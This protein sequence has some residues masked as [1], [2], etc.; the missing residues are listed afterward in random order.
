M[1]IIKKK[2]TKDKLYN[3]EKISKDVCFFDIETT[4][5][6][7]TKDIIYLVGVL[8][9]DE[10]EDSWVL[11]QYFANELKDEPKILIES[12]KLLMSFKTIINY[13]GNTFDIPFVNHKLKHFKLPFYIDKEKS[14]DI[15]SVIRKNKDLLDIEN[16]KLKTVERYLNIY[17]EDIYSGKDCI[18]FYKDYILNGDLELK[19]RLL[20]HNYDDLYFLID[21]IDILD[22]IREKK[23]FTI[24]KDNRIIE[25]LISDTSESK[26]SLIFE[27]NV[28]GLRQKLIYYDTSFNL[29]IEDTNKFKIII[30]TNKGL[31]TTDETCT[32]IDKTDFNISKDIKSRHGY[33]LPKDIF[34]LKVGSKYLLE[35]ILELLKNI[36]EDII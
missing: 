35:D 36:I 34:L 8:Y 12:S 24:R 20:A 17:R 5:F 32:F 33:K 7:R 25:F 9:F 3:N 2:I 13:N 26:D 31:I 10:E 28:E 22:I 1:E 16:L 15:Y 30:Y 11:S 19:N 6:N 4:G 23:S 29:L 27:G 14:L 21:I 18:D